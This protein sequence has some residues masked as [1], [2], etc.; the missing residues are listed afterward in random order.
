MRIYY[1]HNLI[2]CKIIIYSKNSEKKLPFLVVFFKNSLPKN[3]H[4]RWL[5][6]KRFLVP[7]SVDIYLHLRKDTQQVCPKV[8]VWYVKSFF[9]YTTLECKG[10][11]LNF[12]DNHLL[13]TLSLRSFCMQKQHFFSTSS[14]PEY[15]DTAIKGTLLCPIP[16]FNP[17]SASSPEQC[18]IYWK[19]FGFCW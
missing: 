12:F 13:S 1:I 5:L 3:F 2:Q 16:T 11:G 14:D 4:F 7:S 15:Q 17:H 9:K 6:N 19:T 8:L 18:L 10:S